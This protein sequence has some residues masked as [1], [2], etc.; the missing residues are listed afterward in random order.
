[1]TVATGFDLGQRNEIDLHALRLG[2]AIIAKLRP[3][4]DARGPYAQALLA[5]APLF[6]TPSEAQAIDECVKNPLTLPE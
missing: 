4:L 5:K 1:M 6:I 2:P 3:Y